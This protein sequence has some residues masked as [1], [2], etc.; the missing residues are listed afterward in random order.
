MA[1]VAISSAC[2]SSG[3]REPDGPSLT[4]ASTTVEEKDTTC[5]VPVEGV[6]TEVITFGAGVGIAGKAGG[7]DGLSPVD[8]RGCNC[9]AVVG[10]RLRSAGSLEGYADGGSR[11]EAEPDGVAGVGEG[12]GF[13]LV[14]RGGC[15]VAPF[16][17]K[18]VRV[19]A[20]ECDPCFWLILTSSLDGPD[21]GQ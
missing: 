19:V 7:A 18:L 5:T 3:V 15:C 17:G 6:S 12:E 11:S 16:M 2:W 14:T 4:P 13:M 9:G 1:A 10:L 20:G 8:A 21:E